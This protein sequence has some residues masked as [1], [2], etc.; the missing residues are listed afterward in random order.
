MYNIVYIYI[1]IISNKS[2]W[3]FLQNLDQLCGMADTDATASPENVV[4]LLVNQQFLMKLAISM[5]I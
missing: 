3:D 4:L 5:A 1:Y 2:L